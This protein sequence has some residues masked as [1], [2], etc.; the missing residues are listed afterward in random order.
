MEHATHPEHADARLQLRRRAAVRAQL[1]GQLRDRRPDPEQ[2]VVRRAVQ[3]RH[4][5]VQQLG[6]VRV[7]VKGCR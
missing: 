2:R 3:H 5:L 6:T 1:L 7:G 4:L